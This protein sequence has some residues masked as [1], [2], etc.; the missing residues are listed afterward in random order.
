LNCWPPTVFWRLLHPY[1]T[2][3]QGLI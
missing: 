3:F 2:I 1:Q